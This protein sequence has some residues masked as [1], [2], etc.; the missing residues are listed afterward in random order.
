[1]LLKTPI[2][3]GSDDNW[4]M[5]ELANIPMWCSPSRHLFLLLQNVNH[6][7][8]Y[9]KTYTSDYSGECFAEHF[10]LLISTSLKPLTSLQRSWV[11]VILS[12]LPTSFLLSCWASQGLINSFRMLALNIQ[13]W[14]TVCR[15]G[16]LFN[17]CR[18]ASGS[19][20][21]YFVLTILK[22]YHT[23]EYFQSWQVIALSKCL[24][25]LF[26]VISH[27]TLEQQFW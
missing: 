26:V 4:Q 3:S 15:E 22:H 2:C 1:L 18:L 14:S 12:Y 5:E 21:Y 13:S 9:M 17:G 8:I 23:S 20:C 25:K 10:W 7:N 27:W 19:Q 24:E 11:C 16:E 6:P